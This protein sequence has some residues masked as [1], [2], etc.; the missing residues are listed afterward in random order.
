MCWPLLPTI[1]RGTGNGVPATHSSDNGE[2][3]VTD[4]TPEEK[5]QKELQDANQRIRYLERRLERL[6]AVYAFML[7]YDESPD[8]LAAKGE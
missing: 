1:T 2:G 3:T 5:L 7:K 8:S 4:L 6:G